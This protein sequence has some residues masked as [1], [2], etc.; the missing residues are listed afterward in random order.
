MLVHI[1]VSLGRGTF[2]P[3]PW[4]LYD[5]TTFTVVQ[6]GLFLRFYSIRNSLEV[7]CFANVLVW[8]RFFK[9]LQN[10]YNLGVLVIILMKVAFYMGSH[11]P[12]SW[13]LTFR[14]K[15]GSIQSD[16]T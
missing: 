3:D 7:M 9:Y 11:A 4:N 1:G 10:D 12:A 13:D 5:Y 6:S 16:A 14:S 2:V 15:V 8:C